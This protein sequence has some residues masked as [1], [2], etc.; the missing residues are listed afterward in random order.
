MSLYDQSM[1]QY[2]KMLRNMERWLDKAE[3]HAAAK[4]FDVNVLLAARLAPDQFPLVRQIQ[5]ACDAAKSGAAHLAGLP[6]PKHPDVETTFPE[7]RARIKTVLDFLATVDRASIDGQEARPV[8]LAFMPGKVIDATDYL[9]ELSLP[10]F[11]FHA[12][13]VYQ[14]LRHNGVELGKPDFIGGMKLRDA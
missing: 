8:T 14:L 13:T 5:A 2:A 3:A 4:K 7:I 12:T 6:L 1:P 11:Y 9:H 10:N